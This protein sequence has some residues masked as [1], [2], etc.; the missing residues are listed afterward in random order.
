M[1][2]D[3]TA[4]SAH[5]HQQAAPTQSPDGASYP[6]GRSPTG[7]VS[8]GLTAPGGRSL[9]RRRGTPDEEPET[10]GRT[11]PTRVAVATACSTSPCATCARAA[12]ER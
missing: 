5:D 10:S 7:G 6:F 4:T 9:V 8:K 3:F 12:W 11:Q 2:D 1:H